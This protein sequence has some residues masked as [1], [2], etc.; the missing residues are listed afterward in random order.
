MLQELRRVT[1]AMALET[2]ALHLNCGHSSHVNSGIVSV[3]T[4]KWQ[5]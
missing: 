5:C 2:K 1:R 3:S 4:I